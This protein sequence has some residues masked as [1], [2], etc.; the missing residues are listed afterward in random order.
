MNRP[1]QHAPNAVKRERAVAAWQIGAGNMP[2]D[3]AAWVFPLPTSSGFAVVSPVSGHSVVAE[4][5]WW[6]VQ[7][8]VGCLYAVSDHNFRKKYAGPIA[9][10]AFLS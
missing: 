5:G 8:E 4:L 3:V 10:R 1:A 2:R 9:A 7:T 6:V